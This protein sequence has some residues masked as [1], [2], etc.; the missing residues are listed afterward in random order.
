VAL[1]TLKAMGLRLGV[2]TNDAESSARRQLEALGLDEAIEFVAGYDSGHGAKP[3]AGM[4]VAFARH[5]GVAPARVAMVGD[6]RDDLEA[7]RAAGALAV[8]VLSGP[9]D[10]AELAPLADHIVD[11]IAALP[12][13]FA[14]LNRT[15]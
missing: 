15:A 7:A 12:A 2:A 13:L 11:D 1:A 3:G 5:L 4:V 8:A 10:R 9:A 14:E 6:S